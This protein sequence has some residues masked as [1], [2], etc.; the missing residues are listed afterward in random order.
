MRTSI[1]RKEYFELSYWKLVKFFSNKL[2]N[3]HYKYF[4]TD[5]FS[6]YDTFYNNK[7][8][9]DIGCGPR[10]SLEWAD[11]SKERIG[12]DPLADKYIRMG[13]NKHKM[14]YIKGYAEHLPF[15]DSHFDVISSF[16][17]LDHVN[18]IP[19]TCIEIYRTL[20]QGGIFLLI[21][22][23]HKNQTITE[24]Q[25]INWSL[26]KDHFHHFVIKEE[27]H[28]KKKHKNKIYKNVRF[29]EKIDCSTKT[30]GIL[31]VKL[32]KKE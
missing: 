18:D 9:L 16:N 23:I 3:T 13:G 26:L 24:P 15:P 7:S 29:D 31:T 4:Y 11:M 10:G 17:S 19:A 14:T 32:I 2:D 25:T 8:I 6:L 28:L 21:V 5:Y 12:I 30:N 20:K 22:D 27:N 1:S